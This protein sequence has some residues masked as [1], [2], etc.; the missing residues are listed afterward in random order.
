LDWR[1]GLIIILILIIIFLF[2]EALDIIDVLPSLAVP[3]P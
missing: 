2:A 3:P 1:D